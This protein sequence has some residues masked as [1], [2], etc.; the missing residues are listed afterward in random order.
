[1][2]KEKILGLM[3]K[4]LCAYSDQH[5]QNYFHRVQQ[6]GLTEHGFPRLTANI[7]ILIAHGRRPDLLPL[8]VEMME[9]CC[10]VIPTAK[11][12]SH[13][14]A[15]NDFSVR[16]MISCLWEVE[17]TKL[18][19]VEMTQRWRAY[20]ASI[21]PE[22]CYT[23][24]ATSPTD[25]F[26][27][28]VLFTTLSEYFRQA[29]HLCEAT[30]FIELQLQQQLQWFD[31][32]GMYMDSQLS[33][34]HQDIV[35]DLVPR[36]LL[37]LLLDQGYRGKYYA[38]IDEILRKSA[39]L[40]LD[41]QSPN[42]EIPFGGRSN[43]F[44]H[45]EAWLIITFEYE[46]KRYAKE[47]NLALASRFKAASTRALAVIESWLTKIPIRHIK[48]RFPT[49]TFYGCENYAYFD[50]YMIT[51]ASM[52]YIAYLICDDSIPFT[53][54][55]DHAPCIA[56]T[57]QYFHKLFLKAG[58]Y[59]LEF[60]LD[61]YSHYDANGLGRIHKEDA[62]SAICLSCPCPSEPIYTVDIPNP[63][64]LSLCSAIPEQGSWR[65]GA[66]EKTAKYQV[67]HTEKMQDCAT[68]T[69]LC[70]FDTDHTTKEQ[71]TVSE[72]GVSVTVTGQ[73]TIG[74]VL[75]AFFFDGEKHSTILCTENSLDILYEGYRCRYTTNGEII[76]L[77]KIAANRN[78]HYRAFIAA[79]QNILHVDI[80][81]LKI[82]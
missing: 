79:A 68:A 19:P 10:K 76:D 26:R 64:S 49:E 55:A 45:N 31:E 71:Y 73:G 23:E 50:K 54:I 46:A 43:Q 28:Y 25:D 39:L 60:D 61:A 18:C 11:F 16:E 59:G 44:L 53:A 78:G 56:V 69:L 66:E 37:S 24:F 8:F 51:V 81:I 42:G 14:Q 80:E 2:I 5:I 4:S 57:S 70:Q 1:M 27:N 58:G 74:F 36:G 34:N 17:N 67:L 6:N 29:A 33:A 13:S 65:F 62:P 63:I 41:M 47:R 72:N 7:G 38:V 22:N 3:E 32:N 15:C 77:Y 82:E 35:Y 75:P 48:N 52:L 9:L 30:D 12:T 21:T 40:T 20:L